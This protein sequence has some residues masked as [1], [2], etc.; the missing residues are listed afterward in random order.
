MHI[1]MVV[2]FLLVSFAYNGSFERRGLRCSSL[3]SVLLS[4][5][6][7]FVVVTGTILQLIG[8]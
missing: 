5:G 1:Y 8:I 2:I 3:V 6:C 7:V 4:L